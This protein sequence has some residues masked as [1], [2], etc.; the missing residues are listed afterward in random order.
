MQ[1]NPL[2]IWINEFLQNA[3]FPAVVLAF[4]C[5]PINYEIADLQTGRFTDHVRAAKPQIQ[6]IDPLN[7]E[8]WYQLTKSPAMKQFAETN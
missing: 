3:A 8:G 5:A 1:M 6:Y 7:R 2:K 4:A